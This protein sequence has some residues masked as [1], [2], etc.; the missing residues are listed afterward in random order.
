MAT[1]KRAPSQEC[2]GHGDDSKAPS[3]KKGVFEQVGSVIP[4]QTKPISANV[5]SGN[6]SGGE[7]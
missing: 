7:Q 4:L 3:V 1:T 2:E 6:P 5:K